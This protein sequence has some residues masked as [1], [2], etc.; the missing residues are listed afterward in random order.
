MLHGLHPERN[1]IP[2]CVI[3]KELSR[4]WVIS[5]KYLP[6][7]N[8]VMTCERFMTVRHFVTCLKKVMVTRTAVVDMDATAVAMADGSDVKV[9]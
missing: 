5:G 6:K 2:S 1:N 8:S 9:C 4:G 3:S 7:E